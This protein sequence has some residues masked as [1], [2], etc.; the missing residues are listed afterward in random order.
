[1][2]GDEFLSIRQRLGFSRK[3]YGRALGFAG[4]GKTIFKKITALE[5]GREAIGDRT[6]SIA[7]ALVDRPE[8]LAN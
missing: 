8:G 4:T 2:N 3:A 5:D 1:M 7:R 6:A